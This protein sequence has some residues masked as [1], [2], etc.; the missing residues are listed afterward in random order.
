MVWGQWLVLVGGVVLFIAA[1]PKESR[2][3]RGV[4][5]WALAIGGGI[6]TL[7]LAL[8]S[9]LIYS[10]P[11]LLPPDI[12]AEQVLSTLPQPDPAQFDSP[13]K[14]AMAVRG[15]YVYASISC[16]F[17]H[18]NDGAGGAKVNGLGMGTLWTRNISQHPVNGIGSWT[19][20]EIARA[21]RS[22]VSKN[23]RP[24]HWQGMPW[25]HFSNLDEED[26][27]SLVVFLR[28][29]PPV[30]VKIPDYRP[31]SPDDCELYTFW[32]QPG[33]FEPGCK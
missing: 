1:G 30:D 29:L 17:C 32:V 33:N 11:T 31:P 24:L 12:V 8:V 4:K 26:V 22:G 13:E 3:P 28:I 20:E 16:A 23:G 15:R 9:A 18:G 27:Q 25:D 2:L 19:D 21:I 7:I 6:V 5:G 14:Y 10:L